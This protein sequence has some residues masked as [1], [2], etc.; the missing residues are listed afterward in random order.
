MN[1]LLV[2]TTT[3]KESTIDKVP[4]SST[5]SVESLLVVVTNIMKEIKKTP[6]F[7]NTYFFTTS[8]KC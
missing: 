5:L 2:T 8:A 6:L 7:I 1:R 4:E 3:S